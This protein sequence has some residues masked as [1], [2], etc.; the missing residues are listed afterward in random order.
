MF[1]PESRQARKAT[2]R[3]LAALEGFEAGDQ[4]EAWDGEP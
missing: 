1:T 4:L 2:E 3:A